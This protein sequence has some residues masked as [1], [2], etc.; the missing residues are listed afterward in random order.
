MRS[1]SAV[2]ALTVLLLALPAIAGGAPELPVGK[3]DGVRLTT[4]PKGLRVVFTADAERLWKRVAGKRVSVICTQ[5]ADAHGVSE[6]G[7]T[8]FRAPQRGR[9]L[10]TGDLTPNQDY[11]RVW[12]PRR[13]LGA[14][15]RGRDVIAC[16]AGPQ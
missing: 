2:G 16:G 1:I 7:E 12:L 3:A 4:G 11:C 8:T 9:V 5:L 10:P 6:E 15:S 13:N 14:E